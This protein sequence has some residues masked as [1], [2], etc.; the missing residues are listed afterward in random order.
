MSVLMSSSAMAPS[1]GLNHLRSVASSSSAG[2]LKMYSSMA[3]PEVTFVM[4]SMPSD[5]PI[6]P[7]SLLVSDA[8]SAFTLKLDCTA[9]T[10]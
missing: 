5:F 10:R 7:A 8:S 4:R 6:R 1:I 9:P 2:Y 3:A